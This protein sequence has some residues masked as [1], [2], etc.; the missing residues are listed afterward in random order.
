MG[1]TALTVVMKYPFWQPTK[2]FYSELASIQS[3]SV[4]QNDST[5]D[6]LILGGSAMS[7]EFGLSIN[8]TLDSLLNQPKNRKKARLFNA[9]TPS[10]TSLD[11][12]NKYRM[13]EKQRF[14]LVIYYEAIN[15]T[16]ANNIP[17]ESF[18]DDYK[19]II[20]YY[21]LALI[22]LHPEVNWTVL[23]FIVHKSINLLKDK[24]SG[25]KFLELHTANPDFIQYGKEIKTTKPYRQ[26]IV[27]IVREAQ[28]RQEKILL[29]TYALYV[30]PSVIGNGGY[31]DYRDFA[32]CQYPSPLWLWGDPIN[33][34]TGVR[35]HN[36]ALRQVATQYHTYFFDMDRAFDRTKDY[37]CDLCH[38]SETGG[39]HFA[40]KLNKYLI[41]NHLINN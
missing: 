25:K 9:A 33:V 23:P 17:K 5:F 13:L 18:S 12:L 41:N 4:S 2:K 14:D 31:T 15:E 34:E 21:D 7:R 32:A 29:M 27:Q 6:V 20:W 10:H 30:P 19:H 26:N 8:K 1:R 35:Q 28:K 40:L 37:Y 39:K 24:L 3:T 36:E 38:L 22:K 16:R 11:N